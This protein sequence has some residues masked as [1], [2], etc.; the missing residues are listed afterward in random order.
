MSETVATPRS[1]EGV[2]RSGA[3]DGVLVLDFGGQYS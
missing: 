2:E 1:P 3:T